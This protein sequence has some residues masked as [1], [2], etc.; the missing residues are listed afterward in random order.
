MQRR[1]LFW[2]LNRDI[3]WQQGGYISAVTEDEHLNRLVAE[4]RAAVR[5]L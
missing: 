4:V 5:D 2:L 3:H 1:L